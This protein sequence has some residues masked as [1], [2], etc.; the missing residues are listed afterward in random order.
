MIIWVF[1]RHATEPPNEIRN[2]SEEQAIYMREVRQRN[3]ADIEAL[4][5]GYIRTQRS[6]RAWT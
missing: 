3:R 5:N 1:Y 2:M 4:V 6:S